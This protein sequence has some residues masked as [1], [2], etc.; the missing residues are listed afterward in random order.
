MF[1]SEFNLNKFIN[2]KLFE[3]FS[4]CQFSHK[5]N[6]NT[7]SRKLQNLEIIIKGKVC[8]SIN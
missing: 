2:F 8:Y 1:E 3:R 4:I 5:F 6:F 7:E